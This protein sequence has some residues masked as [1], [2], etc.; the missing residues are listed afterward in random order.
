MDVNIIGA[1][2]NSNTEVQVAP[3]FA[4]LNVTTRPLEYS[5]SGSAGVLGGHYS[6]AVSNGTSVIAAGIA[7]QAQVFQVRW[8]DPTKLF[9]LKKLVVTTITATGFAATSQGAPLDL[10]VGHGSTANGSGGTAAAPTSI[11]NRLRQTM[12]S[13]AFA[14]SGEI[15]I[16]STGALTAATGQTLEPAA[17]SYCAGATN[18]AI[19][20]ATYTLFDMNDHG[21]HA[22][23][24]NTGDT[25]ALRTNNP[26]A[27][28]T[29]YLGVTMKWVEATS[30]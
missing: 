17:I 10:W 5:P 6:L 18:A 9:I 12:A 23:V 16:A 26:A 1:G 11:S 28:G 27:T 24:L 7:N 15:R 25:L 4:A 29:W 3:T 20:S 8:A 21:T 19:S 2:V 22:L 13:T 14:T 30:Y